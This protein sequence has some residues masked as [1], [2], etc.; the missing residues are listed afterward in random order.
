MKVKRENDGTISFKCPGCKHYH[1]LPVEPGGKTRWEFNNDF[2][3]PTFKPSILFKTTYDIEKET[4]TNIVCHSFVTDGKVQFLSDCTHSK[5]NQ[6][7]GL[8]ELEIKS[9]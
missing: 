9:V 1:A 5:V 6:T 7:L 3:K 8:P 2:E 4:F